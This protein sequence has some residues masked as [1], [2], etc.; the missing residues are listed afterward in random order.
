MKKA[1]RRPLT[2][3]LVLLLLIPAA[4]C[5]EPVEDT[6]VTTAAP[7]SDTL[8][9]EVDIYADLPTG[10]YNG[11]DFHLLQYEETTA[12]TSTICVEELGGDSV[13]DAIYERTL[14]VS[15]RLDVNIKFTATSLPD[16]NTKVINC[17]M[18][19]D[20]IYQA[21]WQHS[22]N[23]VTNFLANGYAVELGGIA[24][25]DFSKPWWNDVAMKSL[26][27]NDKTYMAFGDIN[28]YLFDFHSILIFNQRLIEQYNL[29]NPYDLVNDGTW[30]MDAFLNLVKSSAYDLNGDGRFGGAKDLIGFTAF[31]TATE[32]AFLHGAD[33]SLFSRDTDG[34]LQY[35]GVSEDYFDVLSSYSEVFGEAKF[36]EHNKDYLG[37]FRNELTMFTGCGVGELSTMRDVE[38]GFGVVPYPKKDENQ[39]NYISFVSNQIQPMVI[40]SSVVNLE[41]AGVVL[42]NLCAESY[43]QVRDE[44]FNVLLEAKYVRDEESIANLNMIYSNETRFEI[45]HVYNWNGIEETVTGALAGKASTFMSSMQKVAPALEKSIEKTLNYLANVE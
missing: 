29:D 7:I 13:H 40:P 43:R 14:T 15:D 1:A 37:R 6:A 24:G 3:L 27:L 28:Y 36:A 30:T 44:Y 16:V 26:S 18:S 32:F 39:E 10:D 22:T 17:V 12:A 23:T 5:S 8:V 35:N 11:E 45:E 25:F 34:N 9:Q 33:V 19:S 4:A 20:D 21:F 31:R 2:S 41:R 42:E 38:F